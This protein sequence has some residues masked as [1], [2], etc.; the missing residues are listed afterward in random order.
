MFDETKS[1]FEDDK[2]DDEDDDEPMNLLGKALFG[3]FKKHIEA[4]F[5]PFSGQTTEEC[6][7]KYCPSRS[8]NAIMDLPKGTKVEVKAIR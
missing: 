4:D 1:D 8:V 7:L 6:Q 3:K 2:D 5:K